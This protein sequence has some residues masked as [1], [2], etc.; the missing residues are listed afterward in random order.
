MVL[1]MGSLDDSNVLVVET[2]LV[3][4]REMMDMPAVQQSIHSNLAR[5]IR[6]VLVF[7]SPHSQVDHSSAKVRYHARLL[8]QETLE[9]GAITLPEIEQHMSLLTSRGRDFLTATLDQPL[10]YSLQRPLPPVEAPPVDA[11]EP[12][13]LPLSS[14]DAFASEQETMGLSMSELFTV[15]LGPFAETDLLLSPEEVASLSAPALPEESGELGE[16]MAAERELQHVLRSVVDMRVLRSLYSSEYEEGLRGLH[17]LKQWLL[18]AVAETAEFRGAF[19]TLYGWLLDDVEVMVAS[20]M[21]DDTADESLL[22]SLLSV[23]LLPFLPQCADARLAAQLSSFLLDR[24]VYLTVLGFLHD[25]LITSPAQDAK[26][27]ELYQRILTGWP[28]VPPLTPSVCAVCDVA[29][30]VEIILQRSGELEPEDRDEKL[31]LLFARMLARLRETR[32]A[33]LRAGDVNKRGC[34]DGVRRSAAAA[35]AILG[36]LA[37]DPAGD[38]PDASRPHA[39]GGDDLAERGVEAEDRCG[40]GG[41][42]QR[43]GEGGT[44]RGDL[45]VVRDAAGG[46]NEEDQKRHA[47]TVPCENRFGTRA[48]TVTEIQGHA[49]AGETEVPCLL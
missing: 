47:G 43:G 12:T 6:L 16:V 13:T 1:L 25:R 27:H 15:D 23:L 26:R 40:T 9:T 19:P 38:R 36:L 39:E 18:D 7:L 48:G 20:P 14:E 4:F 5:I 17:T 28:R 29:Q 44:G 21:S 8:C 11:A 46:G 30:L 33:G 49:N 3:F 37:A 22:F 35:G 10:S 24:L 2:T 34:G 32:L 42:D 45:G 41:D 31:Q